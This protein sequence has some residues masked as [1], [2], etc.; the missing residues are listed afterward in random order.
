MCGLPFFSE[1]PGASTP[2]DWP[3]QYGILPSWLKIMWHVSP[4]ACGPTMRLHDTTF[5]VNGALF[6]YVLSGMFFWSKYGSASRK[7][8]SAFIAVLNAELRA[9]VRSFAPSCAGENASA[10]ASRARARMTD[11]IIVLPPQR[12]WGGG[13]MA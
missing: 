7:S 3:S 10:P 11:F 4:V 2:H 13:V 9:R 5:E 12:C 6:L 8:C 1:M